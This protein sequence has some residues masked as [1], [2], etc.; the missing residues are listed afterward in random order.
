VTTGESDETASRQSLL[1]HQTCAR[2]SVAN[3][4]STNAHRPRTLA[5]P[6]Q[7]QLRDR[8]TKKNASLGRLRSFVA[9]AELSVT[10]HPARQSPN[11]GVVVLIRAIERR[12]LYRLR[13]G[14]FLRERETVLRPGCKCHYE[15]LLARWPVFPARHNAGC[16]KGC[17]QVPSVALPHWQGRSRLFLPRVHR[18]TKYWP[19]SRHDES[20]RVSARHVILLQ[21]E[22]LFR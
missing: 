18:Q 15:S 9:K 17:R 3:A 7:V 16:P 21:P 2:T 8:H 5:A 12:N 13:L 6:V 19:A 20:D 10:K 1:D 14:A 4:S 11:R 22:Y